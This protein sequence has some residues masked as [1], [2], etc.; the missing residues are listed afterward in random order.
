MPDRFNSVGGSGVLGGDA[1]LT[2]VVGSYSGT[3]SCVD[4]SVLVSI[5]Y[6]NNAL[7]QD[8]TSNPGELE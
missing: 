6:Y 4:S 7:K 8:P 3:E 1:S 2:A 5:G